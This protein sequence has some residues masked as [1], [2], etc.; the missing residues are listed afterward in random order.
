MGEGLIVGFGARGICNLFLVLVVLV[1]EQTGRCKHVHFLKV[2]RNGSNG[3]LFV[4]PLFVGGVHSG[5]NFQRVRG[6]VKVAFGHLEAEFRNDRG[7]TAV[8]GVRAAWCAPLRVGPRRWEVG[9]QVKEN[10]DAARGRTRVLHE[11]LHVHDSTRC[12]EHHFWLVGGQGKVN[13]VLEHGDA[14]VLEDHR[15]TLDVFNLQPYGVLPRSDVRLVR[16]RVVADESVVVQFQI[17]VV[18]VFLKHSVGSVGRCHDEVDLFDVVS[19]EGVSDLDG[20]LHLTEGWTVVGRPLKLLGVVPVASEHFVATVNAN[21]R[22]GE[23]VGHHLESRIATGTFHF[24][25]GDVDRTIRRPKATGVALAGGLSVDSNLE[26][27]ALRNH[28]AVCTDV[29]INLDHGPRT[30]TAAEGTGRAGVLEVA[31]LGSNLG[32]ACLQREGHVGG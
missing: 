11:E 28:E 18:E 3:H 7:T 16:E 5:L 19:A 32:V 22:P 13:V 20:E 9:L 24:T 29:E 2:E 26:L 23:R 12:E 31:A 14:G 4:L 25:E 15:V 21:A 17:V 10:I 27:L 1:H 6:A 30:A 8:Q